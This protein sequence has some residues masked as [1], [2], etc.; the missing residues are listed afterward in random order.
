V[1]HTVF[2]A[3]DDGVF[4]STDD[5][6]SWTNVSFGTIH[7]HFC[8]VVAVSP[9]FSGDRSVFVATDAGVYRSQ[10]GGA[11]WQA[12]TTFAVPVISLVVASDP[13]HASRVLFAGLASGGLITSSDAGVTWSLE[14]GFPRARTALDIAVSPGFGTDETVIVGT[15][16]GVW[17]SRT[18]GTTWTRAALSGQRVPAVAISP[19]F[20]TD[21]AAFAGS[22][23]GNGVYATVDAGMTWGSTG[24]SAA[25]VESIAVSPSFPSDHVLFAGLAGG[26]I[27]ESTDAGTTWT[28]AN[29][30]L[31]AAQVFRLRVSGSRLGMAGNGGASYSA[32]PATSWTDFSLPATFA[33][34]YGG[35]LQDV[36]VGT[37]GQGLSI[38]HDGGQTWKTAALPDGPVSSIELSPGY[39]A[40]GVVLVADRYVYVSVDHGRSWKQ[41]SGILGNDVQRFAFS[42]SFERDHIVFAATTGHLIERSSDGGVSWHNAFAGLPTAQINDVTLSPSFA[43][44]RTVFAATT[45]FGIYRSVDDGTTWSPLTAQPPDS[46]VSAFLWDRSGALLAGTERGVYRLDGAVWSSLTGGWDDVVTDLDRSGDTLFI[47]TAGDGVWTLQLPE[48]ATPTATQTSAGPTLT[49]TAAPTPTAT[50]RPTTRVHSL[51]PHIVVVPNPMLGGNPALVRVQGPGNGTVGLTLTSGAWRRTYRGRLAPDGREAF[52]FIAPPANMSVIAEVAGR[53][54]SVTVRLMVPVQ[55][56][57][58]S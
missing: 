20:S 46:V 47:G 57:H 39:A 7:G 43:L 23:S 6:Q 9:Q 31:H 41:A 32:M 18:A 49:A 4:A 3:A 42:P 26:G 40:D 17:T 2:A 15:D 12:P 51:H 21:H 8:R 44:D 28:P 22:A 37:Q 54:Q 34:T 35:T 55:P 24:L 5:G 19:A 36:Y 25:Y 14:T 11:S 48:A 58:R 33:T 56:S 45:G 52:G 10:D 1:D 38:S 13:A 29:N 53:R 16:N 50:A 30:G 27:E